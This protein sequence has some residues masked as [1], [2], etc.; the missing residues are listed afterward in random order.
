M[1]SPESDQECERPA[2][3]IV[4]FIDP[5]V[6]FLVKTM[7]LMRQLKARDPRESYTNVLRPDKKERVHIKGWQAVLEWA[8]EKR[9]GCFTGV[10][11]GLAIGAAIFWFAL[12]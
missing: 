8:P 9:V 1:T 4:R 10:L 6:V 12:K 5:I 11:I 7:I 2:N 3:F